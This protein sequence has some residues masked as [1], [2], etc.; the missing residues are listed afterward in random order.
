LKLVRL[1]IGGS[2]VSKDLL[3]LNLEVKELSFAY[4]NVQDISF[5]P[6]LPHLETLR[7]SDCEV[8]DL[9]CL[10]DL[11]GLRRLELNNSTFRNYSMLSQMEQL[12][13]LSIV[14]EDMTSI[15]FLEDLTNLEYLD[16]SSNKLKDLTPL[17]SLSNLIYLDLSRNNIED[18]AP[19]ADLTKLSHLE[20]GANR[21]NDV[22]PI[23][24]LVAMEYLGLAANSVTDITALKDMGMLRVLDME[25][26]GY[27]KFTGELPYGAPLD[28][29]PLADKLDL[30]LLNL[31]KNTITDLSPLMELSEKLGPVKF[32]ECMG[33]PAIL[34]PIKDIE[35]TDNRLA[36]W[37]TIKIPLGSSGSPVA[38]EPAIRVWD[39]EASNGLARCRTLL[40]A[41]DEDVSLQY[42]FEDEKSGLTGMIFVLSTPEETE[43]IS[44][45]ELPK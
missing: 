13:S 11:T 1:E 32:K 20:L 14:S 40:S 38:L 22:G 36:P 44:N 26:N 35:M 2:N 12:L 45:A 8:D 18:I 24:N 30:E 15:A 41:V 16:L 10:V 4:C 25:D 27:Y 19:L 3:P 23:S 6:Y 29:S 42:Q 17:A 34:V 31:N 37:I 43:Y 9:D 28:L 39:L 21:I 7:F 5:L 33:H